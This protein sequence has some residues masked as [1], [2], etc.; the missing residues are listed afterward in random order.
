LSKNNEKRSDVVVS[1]VHFAVE[2]SGFD[3]LF[4]SYKRP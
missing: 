2:R 1:S 3:S 4:N